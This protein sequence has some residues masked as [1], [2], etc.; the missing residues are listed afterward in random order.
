MINLQIL[1]PS[2]LAILQLHLALLNVFLRRKKW[3]LDWGR[4]EEESSWG[5]RVSTPLFLIYSK[6]VAQELN[7]HFHL[8]SILILNSILNR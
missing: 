2:L 1:T 8:F 6:L 7:F 3:S 4:R 5:V